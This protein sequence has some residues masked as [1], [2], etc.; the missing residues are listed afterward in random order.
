M[1]GSVAVVVNGELTLRYERDRALGERQHESLDRM[2]LRMD[3]GITLDDKTIPQPDLGQRAQFVS[4]ELVRAMMAEDE[5][6]VAAMLSWLANRLPDLKQIKVS[7]GDETVEIDLVFDEEHAPQ[8]T[9]HFVPRDRLKP[10][11]H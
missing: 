9:I 5:T 4:L 7:L 6:R 2:D 10:T 3:G 8:Q 11:Q 1:S